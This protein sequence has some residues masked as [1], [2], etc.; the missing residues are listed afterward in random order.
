MS[1]TQLFAVAGRP[2]FHSR[3]PLIFNTLFHSQKIDAVYFRLAA[4][5][6]EEII[7]TAKDMGLSGFNITAP[8]KLGITDFLDEVSEEVESIGAV[9]TVV[10]KNGRMKWIKP[11]EIGG[12]LSAPASKSL[13]I[14][15]CAAALL[16]EGESF[17]TNPSFCDD[18]KA[19]LEILQALGAHVEIEDSGVRITGKDTVQ[20]LT[21]NCGE[22]GLCMR[23]FTPIA[24]LQTEKITLTGKGSLLRRPMDMLEEPLRRLG[25]I[26]QTQD[27]FPPLRVQGP[28]QGGQI[29]IDASLSS[30]HLTG[31]LMALPLCPE[32]SEIDVRLL[33]SL[34]Y[35]EMTHSVLQHYSISISLGKD[36]SHVSIKGNQEYRPSPYKVE[37]DWSGAAFVLVAGAVNGHI[38]L[39]NLNLDSFQADKKILEA[40]KACGAEISVSAES[41]SV[42][43]NV[44]EAF[45]FD[46]TH[47]PD[48]FPPL[49]V[50]ATACRGRSHL[51]GV[52]RLRYKETNRARTLKTELTKIGARISIRGDTMEIEGT[53]LRGFYPGHQEKTA[54]GI[55][56]GLTNGNDLVFRVAVRPPASIRRE[57]RTINLKTGE[58]ASVSARGRQDVCIAL[59]MPVIVEAVTAFALADLAQIEQKTPRIFR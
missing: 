4:S 30:Q 39:T 19:A 47:C 27:G 33:K 20:R 6:C 14:R 35:V 48:L 15:A 5:S 43:K 56:G 13:M 37:G 55:N 22:S 28:I 24:A 12:T 41:I 9:N 38:T 53:P 1:E 10:S 54:G 59:R 21:L 46:A 23:M 29:S 11:S 51:T 36:F 2:I 50:L 34:P 3:S 32:D 31:F 26:C 7:Q 49:A 8:F 18:A 17:I 58:P 42:K 44:L 25:A 45:D 40:L 57:Q 16:S 52:G